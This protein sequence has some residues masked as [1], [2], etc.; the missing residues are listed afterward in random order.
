MELRRKSEPLISQVVT[1]E[2]TEAASKAFDYKFDGRSEFFAYEL[3]DLGEYEIGVVVGASGTGKTQLLK[4]IGTVSSIPF[5][6]NSKAIIS[7]FESPDEGVEKLSAVG[8]NS[9]PSWCKPYSA[10]SNGEQFRANL[11]RQLEDGAIIDEFTSVVDRNVAKAA[12]TSI[13]KYIKRNKLKNVV[14]ATCH[15]DI[16]EWL[17][18]S[19]VIDTSV[20]TLARGSL[21]RPSIRLDIYKTDYKSW[22]LFAQHHYLTG[23]INKASRCYVAVWNNQIVGFQAIIR[24]PSGTVKNAWRGHRTVIL[25]DFQGLG[26]GAR[27]SDAIGQVVIDDGGRYFCRTANPRLGEYRQ[28]SPKWK[29]TSKNKV[30]RK[31]IAKKGDKYWKHWKGDGMRVCYSHEYIGLDN[32]TD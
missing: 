30:H 7:H 1:D 12:A 15:Y 14:L 24:Y 26:L 10:L 16:L 27:M 17:E 29:P 22:R 31:D 2:F 6:D 19:W 8:L 4:E 21:C 3:P 25:P 9:I 13:S 18:P 20:G 23:E 5:W 32:S 28:S 11:A